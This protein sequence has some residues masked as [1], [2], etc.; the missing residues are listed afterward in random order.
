VLANASQLDT[1]GD[2]IGDQCDDDDDND[3]VLDGSDICDKIANADQ[4]NTDGAADGGDACDDDDDNDG[5]ADSADADPLDPKVTTKDV[6]KDGVSVPA[7]CDDANAAI[8]P[9]AAEIAGNAVDENCDGVAAPFAKIAASFSQKVAV[10]R[11]STRFR[12]LDVKG[13]PAGA[14]IILTC[15]TPK[16]RTGCPLK[17]RT[18]T[19]ATGGTVALAG[20]LKHRRLPVG[21]VV[22]VRIVAVNSIAPVARYTTRRNRAPRRVVT[23]ADPT[24]K[25]T[26]C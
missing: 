20:L 1:D 14:A 10:S 18:V 8:K 4:K 23:C 12:R 21:T 3:T 13:A 2:Q 17:S 19:T 16:G 25:A 11:T 15:R 5:V 24:G 7:D 26:T 6:D 9:G 22:V